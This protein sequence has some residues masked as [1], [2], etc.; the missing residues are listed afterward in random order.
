MNSLHVS[1]SKQI[2][3][4]DFFLEKVFTVS[5]VN[6]WIRTCLNLKGL[7]DILLLHVKIALQMEQDGGIMVSTL[8]VSA[9]IALSEIFI[10]DH[11]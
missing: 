2:G 4:T 5:D 3:T 9:D 8:T 7:C 6:L 11:N 1:T 10:S